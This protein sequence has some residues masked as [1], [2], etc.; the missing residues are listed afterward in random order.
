MLEPVISADSHVFEPGDLWQERVDR[1]LR[2]RVPR[3]EELDAGAFMVFED[4]TR[5]PF[6]GFGSAG[7]RGRTS[8]V[9]PLEDVRAG[10]YEAGARLA[11]MDRDGLVAE[12]LYPS[13]AMRL[14][15]IEDPA[16]QG[17]CMRAYNDWLAEF[18]SAAPDR[19]LG[20]ALLP[21]D[22]DAALAELERVARRGFRGVVISGHPARGR[23]YGTDR[24]E[25]L[26]AALEET[27]LPASLH[28]FTGPHEPEP[29]SFLADYTLATGLVV[30]SL[31]LMVF[32]GVFERYPKLRVV[33][34]ENDIGWVAHL[35]LRMDHAFERKGPRYSHPLR[36]G[37]KPSELFR[38]NVRCTFMD[39][40]AGVLTLELTGPDLFMWA[41]DYPHDDSTFPESQQVIERLFGDVPKAQRRK[42]LHDNAA[43][44]FGLA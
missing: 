13:F 41:S 30:R 5:I 24:F 1:A 4:G 14:F 39:D 42:I 27:G 29:D 22:V 18:Q 44:L 17:A 32:T 38:R 35:L 2:E 19:L 11:D 37:L 31:A 7:D 10:G 12:V 26:W 25:K 3:V 43:Q 40:R 21:L 36:S 16:L 23:D 9:M 20:Q 6:V 33:S 28:V 15:T 34:A 8:A